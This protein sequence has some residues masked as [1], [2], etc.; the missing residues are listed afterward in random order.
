MAYFHL[1]ARGRKRRSFIP[2]LTVHG[3]MIADQ[4][5]MQQ[6]LHGHFT[7]VFGTAASGGMTLNF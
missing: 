3:H 6:A 7:A 4:D 2:A 1:I 5:G